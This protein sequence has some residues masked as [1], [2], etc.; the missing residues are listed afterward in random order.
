MLFDRC[1]WF[2]SGS[3]CF[4]VVCGFCLVLG[5]DCFLFCIDLIILCYAYCFVVTIMHCYLAWIVG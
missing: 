3:L 2:D 4:V 1:S 5:F